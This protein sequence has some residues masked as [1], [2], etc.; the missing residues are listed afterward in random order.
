MLIIKMKQIIS[1]IFSLISISFFTACHHDE[2]PKPEPDTSDVR[3]ITL[4]Y[5]VNRSTIGQNLSL[6]EHQILKA[7]SECNDPDKDVDEYVTLVYKTEKDGTPALYET[8]RVGNGTYDFR[9]VMNFNADMTSCN[10]V[11]VSEVL[12]FVADEYP[13]SEKNLFFWGHGMAWTPYFMDHD[14]QKPSVLP[15]EELH[16]MVSAGAP[17]LEAFGGEQINNASDWIDIK[18]LANAIPDNVFRLI[19]FD[20]CYMSSIEVIYEF[21]DKCEFYVGYATEIYGNGLPYNEVLPE[22]MRDNPDYVE[23]GRKLHSYYADNN[24]A[25]TVAVMDMVLL[26]E[27][28]ERSRDILSAGTVLP[29]KTGLLNYS[30]T[31][32]CPYYDFRQYVM[33]FASANGVSDSAVDAFVNAVGNMILYADTY[34]YDFRGVP[35][36]RDKFS[37]INTHF[38]EGSDSRP[39]RYYRTLD[40]YN[41][42]Y[43]P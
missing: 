19:W 36:D 33:T 4:V 14:T 25:V 38:Y 26:E 32:S 2:P 29:D 15:D 34:D 18:D 10:P 6:N 41:R 13:E 24:R 12:N 16:E 30:R 17:S 27:V 23:A 35:I 21:R 5:A 22:I 37:G 3:Q 7:M 20:A 9:L 1:I 43:Q 8:Y 42:V 31:R 40:W 11:R 28:A 39:E